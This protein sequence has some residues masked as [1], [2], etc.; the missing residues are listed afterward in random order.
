MLVLAALACWGSVIGYAK[1]TLMYFGP[2]VITFYWVV[3]M[4]W[5][6]HTDV[7]VPHYGEDSWNWIKGATTTVDRPYPWIFDELHHHLG[8]THV[9]HHL[10]PEIPHYH[11]E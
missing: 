10:F 5:L 3:I 11:A 6:Q 2:Y 4:T 1:M 8:T 7:H 9:L